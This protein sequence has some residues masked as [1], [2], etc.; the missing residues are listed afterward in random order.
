LKGLLSRPLL[1]LIGHHGAIIKT[2]I[3]EDPNVAIARSLGM[4]KIN[5]MNWW[6][7][8]QI[9]AAGEA[10]VTIKAESEDA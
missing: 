2:K 5:A 3:L 7:I 9:G 6:V 10:I 4:R 1:S 8:H